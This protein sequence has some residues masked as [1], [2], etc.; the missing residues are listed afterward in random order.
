MQ[1]L[2]I[3]LMVPNATYAKKKSHKTS[4]RN[5]AKQQKPKLHNNR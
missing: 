3:V 1:C 2:K 4:K 5:I